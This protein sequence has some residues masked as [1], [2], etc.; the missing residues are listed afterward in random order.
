MGFDIFQLMLA[1]DIFIQKQW[2]IDKKLFVNFCERARFLNDKNM[3]DLYLDLSK[4]FIYVDYNKYHNYMISI[5]DKTT[6]EID[7]QCKNVHIMP[8]KTTNEHSKSKSG[9]FVTYFIKAMF[10]NNTFSNN[11]YKFS[12]K[13]V[14]TPQNMIALNGY[15]KKI[16]EQDVVILVDDFVGSGNTARGCIDELLNIGVRNSNIIISTIAVM[17]AGKQVVES[18]GCKLVYEIE[19]DRGITD[20]YG[21]NVQKKIEIMKQIEKKIGIT[22]E[23]LMFGY[24][25]SEGLISLLRT[26]N[27]TFPVFWFN[28]KKVRNAPFPRRD[29]EKQY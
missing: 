28:N 22:D 23:A 3:I 6:K 19:Q 12:K 27:N 24:G 29:Y 9:D 1:R 21:N 10:S 18:L 7:N 8:M 20:Y 26:P 5:I 15:Y 25:Q 2:P 17:K 4:R 13:V 11:T 16:K 14:F